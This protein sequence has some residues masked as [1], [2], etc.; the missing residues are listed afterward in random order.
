MIRLRIHVLAHIALEFIVVLP[1]K[2]INVGVLNPVNLNRYCAKVIQHIIDEHYSSPALVDQTKEIQY[3]KRE[4]QLLYDQ[5]ELLKGVSMLI[6]SKQLLPADEAQ[7]VQKKPPWM[8][9]IKA[10]LGFKR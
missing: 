5:V 8:A 3:L 1:Q 2:K 7:E 9:R 6:A 10:F 4:N